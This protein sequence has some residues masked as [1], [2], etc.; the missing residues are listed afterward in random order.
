MA[1]IGQS[2][3]DGISADLEIAV[4]SLLESAEVAV[5]ANDLD[6]ALNLLT[7]AALRCWWVGADPQARDEIVSFAKAMPQKSDD[8]RL[9]MALAYVAPIE[10]G[11][12]VIEKV[13]TM[14]PGAG[15]DPDS[16]R[17]L[18]ITA[19]AAGDWST[20]FKFYASAI[21]GLRR[22]GRLALLGQTLTHQAWIAAQLGDLR[23]A[24]PIADEGHRLAVE[25]G[26]PCSSPGLASP[27]HSSRA[28]A[29]RMAR[30]K[31]SS[32]KPTSSPYPLAEV[33]SSRTSITSGR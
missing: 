2:F 3:T 28:S 25:T 9:L 21:D 29:V 13:L 7:G 14:R 4:R 5:A 15:L 8:P 23:Y 24:G 20:A 11:G 6:L 1:W 30:P 32:L 12:Y 18:G 16:E 27:K 17:R 33:P 19:G 10:L 22:E 31:H 26:Q